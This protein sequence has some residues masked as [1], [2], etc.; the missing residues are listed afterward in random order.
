MLLCLD[1][2]S[3]GRT[4]AARPDADVTS[5]KIR[6]IMPAIKAGQPGHS[7]IARCIVIRR[8]LMRTP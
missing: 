3:E 6:K 1:T 2:N 5:S 7:I 8:L 4:L